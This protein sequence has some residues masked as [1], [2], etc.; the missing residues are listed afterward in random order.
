MAR[1]D[2]RWEGVPESWLELTEVEERE[3]QEQARRIAKLGADWS[4][5]KEA[6][7]EVLLAV[8][9]ASTNEHNE[10][11]KEGIKQAKANGVKCGRPLKPKPSN[12]DHVMRL[13][14]DGEVS[15]DTVAKIQDVSPSTVR[16][17]F[18]EWKKGQQ[19]D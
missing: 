1:K 3:L 2:S 6:L 11:R 18:K 7:S 5:T 19:A 9:K 14:A 17:W 15:W 10:K 13:L 12:F 16:N 4:P 8:K